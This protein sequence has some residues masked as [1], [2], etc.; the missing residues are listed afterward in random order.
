MVK[1]KEQAYSGRENGTPIWSMGLVVGTG[2]RVGSVSLLKTVP[3]SS[4]LFSRMTEGSFCQ[5][6]HLILA[7]ISL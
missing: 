4:L 5:G 7:K 6:E 1:P 2:N 3:L